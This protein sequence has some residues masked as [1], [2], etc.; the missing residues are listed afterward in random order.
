[1]IEKKGFG[2]IVGN[3]GRKGGNVRQK[4]RHINI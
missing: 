3:K 4:N 1:M 2:R